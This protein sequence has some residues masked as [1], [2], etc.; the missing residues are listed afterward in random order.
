MQDVLV[1]GL[2]PRTAADDLSATGN[3]IPIDVSELDRN[4]GDKLEFSLDHA[5]L[6]SSTTLP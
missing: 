5:A 3:H 6:L 2:T 1:A 4:V